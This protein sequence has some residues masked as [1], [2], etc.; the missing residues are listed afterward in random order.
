MFKWKFNGK[1]VH[2]VTMTSAHDVPEIIFTSMYDTCK[3]TVSGDAT[4]CADLKVFLNLIER[5]LLSD[6]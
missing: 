2:W 6:A 5:N 1:T 4:K 3:F